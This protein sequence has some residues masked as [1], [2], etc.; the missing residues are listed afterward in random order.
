MTKT[1]V[2]PGE[3]KLAAPHFVIFYSSEYG[4]ENW[5]EIAVLSVASTV[6]QMRLQQLHYGIDEE[7]L[8]LMN[9]ELNFYLFELDN[10]DPISYLCYHCS[11]MSNIYSNIHFAYVESITS[12]NLLY[13]ITTKS[14]QLGI[15]QNGPTGDYKYIYLRIVTQILHEKALHKQEYP[16]SPTEY[17]NAL[18]LLHRLLYTTVPKHAGFEIHESCNFI[19]LSK[20]ISS[21]FLDDLCVILNYLKHF[22]LLKN[23]D[24]VKLMKF[25]YMNKHLHQD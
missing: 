21:L 1:M 22:S 17:N 2:V 20:M 4:T 12:K 15:Y 16:L 8:R 18:E 24:I 13:Y 9:K 5:R 14:K 7:I 3:I 23:R 6:D 10:P 25:Y 11:T 19:Q